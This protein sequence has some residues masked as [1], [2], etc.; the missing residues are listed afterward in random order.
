[1]YSNTIPH[2]TMNARLELSLHIVAETSVNSGRMDV[3][4]LRNLSL[5]SK[6]VADIVLRV[7]RECMVVYDSTRGPRIPDHPPFW[8]PL[9][10]V[11]LRCPFV[12]ELRCTKAQLEWCLTGNCM[13]THNA[14]AVFPPRLRVLY[15]DA[16][17]SRAPLRHSFTT[18]RMISLMKED[19]EGMLKSLRMVLPDG[20]QEFYWKDDDSYEL[21]LPKELPPGLRVLDC[22]GESENRTRFYVPCVLLP[23]TLR[24]LRVR[25]VTTNGRSAKSEVLDMVNRLPLPLQVC[26]VV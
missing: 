2:H 7:A 8:S 13:T 26:D 1:M 4:D 18:P 12:Q 24:V 16:S 17:T 25:P 19:D 22:M 23:L 3:Y 11:A 14:D 20:L 9:A 10:P 15:V 21:D 5:A 6:S